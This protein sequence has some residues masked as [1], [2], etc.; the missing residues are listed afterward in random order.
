M[1]FHSIMLQQSAAVAIHT[2]LDSKAT[3]SR[4]LTVAKNNRYSQ[5]IRAIGLLKQTH[6][7]IRTHVWR[8]RGEARE[9]DGEGVRPLPSEEHRKVGAYGL[10]SYILASRAKSLSADLMHPCWSEYQSWF[11]DGG[12]CLP[13]TITSAPGSLLPRLTSNTLPCISL[14]S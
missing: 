11:L 9:G 4:Q 7:R 14:T 1:S 12:E 2:E 5:D 3:E 8:M 10:L 6:T 13:K